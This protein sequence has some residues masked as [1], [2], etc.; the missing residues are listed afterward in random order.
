MRSQHHPQ[1]TTP[2]SPSIPARFCNQHI[3][4]GVNFDLLCQRFNLLEHD[5]S[6]LGFITGYGTCV[7][8]LLQQPV[9]S[10]TDPW[11]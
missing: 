8:Q 11:L 10:V 3:P 5:G 7:A 2:R 1:A 4:Q 9:L 6:H